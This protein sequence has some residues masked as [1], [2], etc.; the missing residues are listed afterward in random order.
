MKLLMFRRNIHRFITFDSLLCGVPSCSVKLPFINTGKAV[1]QYRCR[2]AEASIPVPLA[3][4]TALS[5]AKEKNFSSIISLLSGHP[6]RESVVRILCKRLCT[7]ISFMKVEDWLKLLK[8]LQHLDV[9]SE[10]IALAANYACQKV[11]ESE[12]VNIRTPIKETFLEDMTSLRLWIT[13]F[14]RYHSFVAPLT[15]PSLCLLNKNVEG[16]KE[17]TVVEDLLE[18]TLYALRQGNLSPDS[19]GRVISLMEQPRRVLPLWRWMQFT[20]AK[21][22]QRAASAAVIAFSRHNRFADAVTTLQTLAVVGIHP[23]IAAQGAFLDLLSRTSPP[24]PEYGDQLVEYWYPSEEIRWTSTVVDVTSAQIYLHF[25]CGNYDRCFDILSR[26][27]K[28][29]FASPLSDGEKQMGLTQL[30]KNRKIFN[31]ARYFSEEISKSS[32]LFRLFFEEPLKNIED[33]A[34]C[35]TAVSLFFGIAHRLDEEKRNTAFQRISTIKH[36]IDDISFE[37]I[38]RT[39]AEDL[40]SETSQAT[41][42]FVSG[43]GSLLEKELSSQLVAWIKLA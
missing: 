22:N 41:L 9:S 2:S 18:V 17:G 7:E 14:T 35:P 21:W 1:A 12:N 20:S 8:I 30:I 40:C 37:R 36:L 27:A 5:L 15:L 26:T 31:V 34:S 4:S 19:C 42:E 6:Q 28:H 39:V 16:E 13:R 25:R 43:I 11:S 23:T 32:T 10:T 38:V 33:F 29:L 24:L 3:T